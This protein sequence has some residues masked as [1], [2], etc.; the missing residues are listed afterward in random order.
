[1][2]SYTPEKPY[3]NYGLF[4]V[5][6]D[7][8]DIGIIPDLIQELEDDIESTFDDVIVYGRRFQMGPSEG[9]KIQARIIG[10]DLNEL[11]RIESEVMDTFLADPDLKGVRSD[12][13]NSVKSIQPIISKEGRPSPA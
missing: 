12:W 6:V 9:G 11:R 8:E 7:M 3:S 13:L 4:M 5:D 2:L 10:P 1:M